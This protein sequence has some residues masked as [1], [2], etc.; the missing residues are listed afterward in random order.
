MEESSIAGRATVYGNQ[1]DV[2][3]SFGT[4]RLFDLVRQRVVESST[5][6]V[7]RSL[8]T[9]ESGEDLAF[10][11]SEDSVNE[12]LARYVRGG[13]TISDQQL[14]TL[15][16]SLEPRKDDSLSHI[17]ARLQSTIRKLQSEKS[18]GLLFSVELPE[19]RPLQVRFRDG[20]IRFVATFQVH[21]RL[22]VPAVG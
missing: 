11:V 9:L 10:F 21:P 1:A 14:Q 15:Q 18:D 17:M 7:P 13:M 22:A 20:D 19:K 4:D 16:S 5:A 8:R 2:G 12:L 6:D 3:R